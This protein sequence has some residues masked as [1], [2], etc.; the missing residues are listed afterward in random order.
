M[1][2][3]DEIIK[4]ELNKINANVDIEEDYITL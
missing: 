4:K 3:T 2:R 1:T